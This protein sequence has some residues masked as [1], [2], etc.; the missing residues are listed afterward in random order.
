MINNLFMKNTLLISLPLL[1][2]LSTLNAGQKIIEERKNLVFFLVDDMGYGDLKYL[3]NK[4]IESPNI[5]SFAA[6]ASV[7]T[8]AYVCPESSPTRAGLITGKHPA[9][10]HLTSWIPQK[11]SKGKV[12]NLKGWK[13]PQEETGVSLD[14]FTLAEALKQA[15]Y[16]T[17]HVGKWHIG[18]DERGPLN[19]GFD[20]DPG[21]WPWSYP[22][23]YFS[24]YGIPTLVDG[25][26]GEYITDRLTYEAI[27]FVKENKNKPFFLNFWH[28]A[29]HEPLRAKKTDIDHYL[30]KGAPQTGKDMATYS[31]MKASVDVSF[32]RLIDVLTQEGLL[33]NTVIVFMSDNGGVT[34]HA[35]NGVL[36]EGKKTL[37]EGGIRIPMI[38]RIPDLN[39]KNQVIDN[40]VSLVDF[41]PTMLELLSI[42]K[43]K[44]KQQLDGESY[45]PLF[46]NKPMIRKD[47]ALYW[48]HVLASNYGPASAI[49]VDDYKLIIMHATNKTELYN[50]KDDIGETK[51]LAK[52]EPKVVAKLTK[53]LQKWLKETNAQMPEKI[54]LGD[55]SQMLNKD[56][57]KKK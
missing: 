41:Y 17:C 9:R 15:G 16:T 2:S 39:G 20:F 13:I 5:D 48:H 31:A 28:Y 56:V 57:L 51:N 32:G 1:T 14:E 7:F 49:R 23:S 54:T 12:N 22:K 8:N 26:K 44:V 33:H 29:V 24:P 47:N 43:K 37:Y 46:Y 6:E 42:D 4:I 18:E 55:E 34:K 40:P 45:A 30:T 36:R 52:K 35:D 25:P 27:N 21:Y 3:G 19:Q 50:L 38:I 10:L 11:D 53:K